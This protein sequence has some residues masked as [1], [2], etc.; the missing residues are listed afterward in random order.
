MEDFVRKFT[1]CNY[2]LEKIPQDASERQYFR[3]NFDNQTAILMDC[4][5]CPELIESFIKTT[6]ILQNCE[7]RVPQIYDI[8]GNFLIIEDFGNVKLSSPEIQNNFDIEKYYIKCTAILVNIAKKSRN[9]DDYNLKEYCVEEKITSFDRFFKFYLPYHKNIKLSQIEI[10][11][12]QTQFKEILPQ[13]YEKS[14]ILRDFHADNIMILKNQ[15]IGII[16]YQD[17]SI[18]SIIYD[19]VSILEDV[20][21]EVPENIVKSC[22]KYLMEQF[23][24][25]ENKF[26]KLYYSLSLQRNI[27]ILGYFSRLVKN[28][29][30]DYEKY[31][32]RCEIL[33]QKAIKSHYLFDILHNNKIMEI[34]STIS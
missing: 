33:V 20:R 23:G 7:V 4:E 25:N 6:S 15:T 27:R 30:T 5:K 19:L 10:A 22:K 21:I 13:N 28:G 29:R 2:V 16:D 24:Y 32:K 17:L 8:T 12:F 14:I 1:K 9:F 3:I 26:E 34:I 11:E 31:M 18:G